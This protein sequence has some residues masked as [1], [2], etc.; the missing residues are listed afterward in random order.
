M[1]S[2]ITLC[3]DPNRLPSLD[4]LQQTPWGRIVRQILLAAIIPWLHAVSARAQSAQSYVSGLGTDSNPCSATAPCQT[5][6]AALTKT[7]PGG[8]IYALDSA[9]YGYITINKA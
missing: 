8:Q 2:M 4:A 6:Q 5:L 9:N 3:P 1:S 7:L